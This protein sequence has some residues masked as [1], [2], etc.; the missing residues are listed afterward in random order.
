MAADIVFQFL[1][2]FLSFIFTIMS[3]R[4]TGKAVNPVTIMIV[5]FFL[6]LAISMF[7]WSGLQSTI[8]DYDTYALII[9]T[10]VIWL[11]LPTVYLVVI[12]KKKELITDNDILVFQGPHFVWIVRTFALVSFGAYLLGNYVQTDQIIPLYDLEATFAIHSEFPPIIRLAARTSPLAVVLLFLSFYFNRR[13]LDLVLLFILFLVPLTRLSRIDPAMSL[14]MLVILNQCLP[15]VKFNRRN[16]LL[17]TSMLVV[18]IVVAAEL[19]N[20]RTNRF[21]VYEVDYGDAIKWKL[22][23]TGPSNVF[24]IL[25]GYFPLSFEN[26]DVYVR[27]NRNER[28]YGLVSMDWLFTGLFKMNWIPGYADLASPLKG[29]APVSSAAT[30]P[31]AIS[32]FYSDFGVYGAWLP[33]AMFMI[34]WL[35]L[36]RRTT[37]GTMFVVLY[38]IYAAGFALSSFQAIIAAPIL[39]H[40]LIEFL[41]IYYIAKRLAFVKNKD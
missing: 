18:A 39:A 24:P 5:A 19:G 20:Q 30:V 25:Y 41:I 40:Q 15:L 14:V 31:T 4:S 2:V 8:W 3:V 33:M 1:I 17:T 34:F 9:Q 11:F 28:T 38:A 22:D 27:H 26:L 12:K 23:I 16:L 13:K 10:I 35:E 37:Q 6:P 36:Y 21:G 32:A 7:R 29:Y